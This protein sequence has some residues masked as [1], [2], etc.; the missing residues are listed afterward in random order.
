MTYQFKGSKVT[1]LSIMVSSDERQNMI[2]ILSIICQMTYPNMHYQP[3][4]SKLPLNML[5][6]VMGIAHPI[7]NMRTSD[8]PLWWHAS[9]G[10]KQNWALFGACVTRT[11]YLMTLCASH[12][13]KLPSGWECV[14]TVMYAAHGQIAVLLTAASC[15]TWSR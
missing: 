3:L 5:C 6:F 4:D 15:H 7:S 2:S 8:C 10:A 13:V 14:S 1:Q 9:S 11:A 12:C